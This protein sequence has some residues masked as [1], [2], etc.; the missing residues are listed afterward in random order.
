MKV[1]DLSANEVFHRLR[2][3]GLPLAIGPFVLQ[4]HSD[5]RLIAD[6]IRELYSDFEIPDASFIDFQF[7]VHRVPIWQR[8]FSNQVVTSAEG[9]KLFS[10]VQ[11]GSAVAYWEWGINRCISGGCHHLLML[12][13]AVLAQRDHAL[14]IVGQSGAGKSTLCAGLMFA[15]WRLLSDEFAMTPLIDETSTSCELLGLAQPIAL[16]NKS[17]QVIRQLR[18]EAIIGPV[19]KNTVK[20]DVAHLKP[21]AS[22]VANVHR[23][24]RPAMIVFVNYQPGSPTRLSPVTKGMAMYRLAKNSFNFGM[25]GRKGFDTLAMIVD[26]CQAFE[27]TYC[28][29]DEVTVTLQDEFDAIVAAR[30]SAL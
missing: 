8:I 30:P 7:G 17:L 3:T 4:L 9:E 6:T 12:H 5:V 27:L 13:A 22:S 14:I 19:S 10:N 18:P 1:K 2:R 23:A 16:K 11:L 15:G 25:T 26:Q 28:E 21:D 24:A 29:M 20:G